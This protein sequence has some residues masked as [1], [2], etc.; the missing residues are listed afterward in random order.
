MPTAPCIW[1]ISAAARVSAC[2]Q[3][4]FAAAASSE[5]LAGCPAE[6]VVSVS[7]SASAAGVA[8]RS[9]RLHQDVQVGHPVLKGLEG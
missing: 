6:S 7:P 4:A 9:R 1:I 2:A 5:S 8:Q 3:C